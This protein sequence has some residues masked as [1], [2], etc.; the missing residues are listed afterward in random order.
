MAFISF[1]R[2]ISYYIQLSIW[3]ALYIP[4]IT[5]MIFMMKLAVFSEIG[6]LYVGLIKS[7][8]I[9]PHNEFKPVDIELKQFFIDPIKIFKS[10]V[11]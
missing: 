4:V 8:N 2:S 11:I 1:S 6:L 3:T 7:S 10:Y 9:T 5:T